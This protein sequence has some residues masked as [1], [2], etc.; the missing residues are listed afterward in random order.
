MPDTPLGIGIWQGT[1][2]RKC[3]FLQSLHSRGRRQKTKQTCQVVISA[4]KK[5]GGKSRLEREEKERNY[6]KKG[7]P[8]RRGNSKYKNFACSRYS[9]ETAV[10]MSSGENDGR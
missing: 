5:R 8:A 9:K 3:L 6:L 7:I 2:E 10:A 1:K 4:T